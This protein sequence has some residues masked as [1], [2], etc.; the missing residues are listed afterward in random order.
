MNKTTDTDKGLNAVLAEMV[1]LN[2]A[3]VDVGL[4][5]DGELHKDGG[6]LSVAEIAY[7]NEYG[8]NDG[9]IP[10]RPAHRNAFDDNRAKLDA[11]KLR[12]IRGVADGKLSAETAAKIL[13]ETHQANVQESIRSLSEPANAPSTIAKKGSSNPL[14]DSGQTL[15]SVRYVVEGL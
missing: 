13:G 14:I 9:R 10:P 15:Q 8:T 2:G 11:L 4:Q 12:L 6:G 5:D 7:I 1:R 3:Y